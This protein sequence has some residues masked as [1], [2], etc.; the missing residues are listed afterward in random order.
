MT[1]KLHLIAALAAGGL[2]AFGGAAGAL[3]AGDWVVR[4]GPAY[5]DPTDDSDGVPGVAGAKV[6]ADDAW[7]LGF[8]VGY[9]LTDN[10][11]VD[12]LAATPFKHDIE[13]KG[14]LSGTVATTKQLPPTL[15]LLYYF[16]PHASV[17]PYAGVGVNYT[18]FFDEQT[19]GALDGLDIEL[20]DSVGL[21]LNVG[22]DVDLNQDWFANV[23]AWY[24]DLETEADVETFNDFDVAINPLVFMVGVG[25]TF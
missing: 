4:G 14:S 10:W 19:R 3:E 21:A 17:R 11:S 24:I 12:L 2:T 5:V 16:Q 13:G 25:R 7:A 20:E 15:S 6:E 8:S 22:V 1:K 18:V 9:M 23:S